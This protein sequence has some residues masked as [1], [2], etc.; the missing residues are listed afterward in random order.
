A[1][2]FCVESPPMMLS[3]AESA[4]TKSPGCTPPVHDHQRYV[5]PLR[6]PVSGPYVHVNAGAPPKPRA[7]ATV[8][9][10]AVP[11]FKAKLAGPWTGPTPIVSERGAPPVTT[12]STDPP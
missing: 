6:S 1:R 3:C 2:I 5:F 7:N 10:P 11:S 12:R 8:V 9:L 4:G